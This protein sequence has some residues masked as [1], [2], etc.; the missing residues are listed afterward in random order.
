[1]YNYVLIVDKTNRYAYYSLPERTVNKD[2]L[3]YVL[4]TKNSLPMSISPKFDYKTIKYICDT[5]DYIIVAESNT[6]IT[7]KTHPELFI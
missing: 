1:M 4:E 3:D 5:L 2:K 7:K 6:P